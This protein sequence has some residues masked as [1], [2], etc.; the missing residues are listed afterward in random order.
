MNSIMIPI[1]A[2]SFECDR[3]AAFSSGVDFRPVCCGANGTEFGA[4]KNTGKAGVFLRKLVLLHKAEGVA[5]GQKLLG[6]F[7]GE[8]LETAYRL[9]DN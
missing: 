1:M 4:K 3:P 7:V 2:T 5:N 6:L 9:R 8:L